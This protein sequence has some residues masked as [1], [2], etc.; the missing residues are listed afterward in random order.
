MGT[1]GQRNTANRGKSGYAR[2]SWDEAAT[3]IADELKRIKKQYGPEAVLSQSDGHGEG[4]GIHAAHGCANKLLALNGGYTLQM[5]N[6]DSWEGW[7]WGAKHAWGFDPVGEME[8]ASN[9]MPDIARNSNMVL[10]WGCDPETTSWG[11]NGQIS[12]R[13]CY[14]FTDLGIKQ[15]YICP[16]LNYGAAIHADKWIPVKPGTDAALQLAIAYIWL[17]EDTF[18]KSYIASNTYGFDEFKE[19][20]LGKDDN[21]PKTPEWAAELT[22]IP[23]WT[24]KALAR[25]WAAAP[26]SIAHGNGGAGMRSAYAT[27][28]A[29]LEVLLLAMQ[30]L[31]KPGSHQVKFLE[32][33]LSADWNPRGSPMPQGA[34][35]YRLIKPQFGVTEVGS[36]SL[37]KRGSGKTELDRIMTPVPLDPK[38]LIPKDL[39]HEAIL[40]P[41]VSW[42]GNSTFPGS[43]ADQFVKY[44]YPARG[45]SEIH[46]I[47]TD[48]PCWITCW[49]DSNSFIKALQSPKIEM[50]VAQHQWLEN[51]CLLADII[52]PVS[53]KFEERDMTG[54]NENGEFST[55]IAG[56]KCIEPLGESKSDY[57]AVCMVAEK[58]GLLE[59]YTGGKTEDEWHKIVF[60]H[61][62]LQEKV[63]YEEF[64]EKGYYV[65]PNDTEWSK[66]PVGLKR[67]P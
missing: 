14:W 19:Y 7:V 9:V 57:E 50:V 28:P 59:K 29:R 24:I 48:S 51:D 10:F 27:E 52:L 30:G 36:T 45:C 31:G 13:L 20:V 6:T 55:V 41:P 12:S 42:Y 62:G 1:K 66:Q 25:A 38:Q 15:V 47:W 44:T 21:V 4:K 49:N 34:A 67:I 17:K 60:E 33:G 64:R 16:E 39:I 32:W 63:S 54:D 26:A 8:P 5:R 2:I 35:K 18:D 3:L 56:E 22:G 58:L 65:I 46:M 11:F 37:D 43:A 53:T 23:E 40:R 61:S